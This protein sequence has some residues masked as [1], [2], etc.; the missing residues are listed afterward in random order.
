MKFKTLPLFLILTCLTSKINA[1]I[2][3]FQLGL[4][5]LETSPA[6]SKDLEGHLAVAEKLFFIM[7]DSYVHYLYCIEDNNA[8][9]QLLFTGDDIRFLDTIGE[10]VFFYSHGTK[11]LGISDGTIA[12]TVILRMLDSY[13]LGKRFVVNNKLVIMQFGEFLVSDGT[14]EGT[15]SFEPT[16]S[17]N[18]SLSILYNDRLIFVGNDG[19]HG[20]EL[21]S[22]DGTPEGTHMIKDIFEEGGTLW[23]LSEFVLSQGKLFFTVNDYSR[24]IGKELWVTDGTEAG[25][26]LVKDIRPGNQGSSPSELSDAGD[27]IFFTATDGT[28]GIEIWQSDATE[29][30][31][32]MI[33][34]IYVGEGNS[35]RYNEKIIGWNGVGIFI[36]RDSS[37]VYQI[38][39]S[40]GTSEGTFPLSNLPSTGTHPNPYSLLSH[41]ITSQGKMFFFIYNSFFR[42]NELWVTGGTFENTVLLDFFED[43][44]S[45]ISLIEDQLFFHENYASNKTLRTSDGTLE[46]TQVLGNFY[47]DEVFLPYKNLYLFTL[48][49]HEQG[50]ELWRSDGTIEGTKI[51]KDINRGSGGVSPTGFSIINEKLY[52]FANDPIVGQSIYRSD[53]T[54]EGTELFYD[55]F[56]NTRGSNIAYLQSG[57]G[58]LFFTKDDVLWSSKGSENQSISLDTSFYIYE[59]FFFYKNKGYLFQNTLNFITDGTPQGSGLLINTDPIRGPIIVGSPIIYKD[60]IWFI[61]SHED[62]GREWWKSDGTADG[63]SLAFETLPGPPSFVSYGLGAIANSEYLFFTANNSI[64]G[65][66]LWVSDGTLGGTYLLKDINPGALGSN[67]Y[68]FFLHNNKVFFTASGPNG[69]LWVSNGTSEGTIRL[70]DVNMGN[71][72]FENRENG[73]VGD[74]FFFT[75][76]YTLW[77]TD[78]TS[79]GTYQIEPTAAFS[80][81]G[82][83]TRVAEKVFFSGNI[84]G[85]GDEPWVSDGTSEGT[86][87]LKDI[88]PSRSSSPDDFTGLNGYLFFT[89]ETPSEG[90]EIWI[91]DGTSEGTQ[92]LLDLR[93]GYTSSFPENLTVYKGKLFFIA[94]DGIYGEEIR[95]LDFVFQP[96]VKGNVFHDFNRNGQ[97]DEEEYGLPG[98]GIKAVNQSKFIYTEAS[99]NF[100][101]FLNPGY[102]LIQPD[103]GQCWETTSDSTQY[104]VTINDEIQDHLDFG[105]T[106]VSDYSRLSAYLHSGPTRCGFTVPF[107]LTVKNIGCTALNGRVGL[108]LNDLVEL[109]QVDIA[110]SDESG[111]TLWWNNFAL[112]ENATFQVKLLLKMPSE[113]FDGELITMETFSFYEDNENQWISADGFRFEAP[114]TCAIDPNDKLVSPSRAAVATNNYTAFDELLNYTIRFQN[115]GSDTAINIRIE[116]HLSFLLDWESFKPG[117]SSH[118]YEVSIDNDGIVN[119]YFPNINL[120]DSTTNEIASHGFINFFIAPKLELEEFDEIENEA[121]IFFDFNRPIITNTI[122]NVMLSSL[123]KDEDGFP[124]WEDCLDTNKAVNPNAVEIPNN[125]VD[126]DCDGM[127]LI[128]AIEEIDRGKINIYPNPVKN[129][130][131]IEYNGQGKLAGII[132]SPNGQSLMNIQIKGAMNRF[133]LEGLPKG[134]FFLEIRSNS[135]RIVRKIVKL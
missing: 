20:E 3:D 42:R 29:E 14:L 69:G 40:D 90:K 17:F 84:D 23:S 109:V 46:G 117:V 2:P 123:D 55:L 26:Y 70:A 63:T 66:E 100:S 24:V 106:R 132:R 83:L 114:I 103:L 113:D 27:K 54:A 104:A 34:D 131:F 96:S 57:A 110:P 8:P 135:E 112:H 25:T 67:P 102:E 4:I 86:F 133:N 85:N 31:T 15:Y 107:W 75:V 98:I 82:N 101:F 134:L 94:N 1:Q 99:G 59:D 77:V 121:A 124:F 30:R 28:H 127:D 45:D 62:F 11:E 22:S 88:H 68:N 38:W 60:Q 108:K 21:W 76:G 49:D 126:E 48:D 39:R 74:Y 65:N 87:M 12:G 111:D 129:L 52:F 9:T 53:S 13:N 36:A 35:V 7:K 89:A 119:F 125:G 80:S 6:S 78:G 41:W 61:A 10:K 32:S 105:L 120:P 118:F 95:F 37:K 16:E 116:D 130:L 18:S 44:A 50:A 58:Q 122:K 56:D 5:D 51:L 128:S 79:E 71:T 72:N 81:I 92:L 19:I 115:T 93:E 47:I 43:S 33:K 64:S 97:R 91:S 73:F